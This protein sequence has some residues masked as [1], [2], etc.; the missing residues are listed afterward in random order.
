MKCKR[1]KCEGK[2][3]P[4]M[5]DLINDGIIYGCLKCGKTVEPKKTYKIKGFENEE[6][7]RVCAYCKSDKEICNSYS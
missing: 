6:W 4:F 1:F 5:E 3:V 7:I 2:M